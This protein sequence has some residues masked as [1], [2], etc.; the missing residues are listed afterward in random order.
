M[1]TDWK[2]FSLDFN[3]IKIYD[4]LQ[5]NEKKYILKVL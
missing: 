1:V 5:K 2:Y 3:K 4:F